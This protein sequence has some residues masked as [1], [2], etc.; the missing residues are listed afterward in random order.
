MKKEPNL[1]GMMVCSMTMLEPSKDAKKKKL[2]LQIRGVF[3]STATEFPVVGGQLPN[4]DVY[5]GTLQ[6]KL[7]S[8][9]S[10]G[11]IW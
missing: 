11:V 8:R 5:S 4:K 2:V 9:E 3:Y 10:V 7:I 6:N 1:I